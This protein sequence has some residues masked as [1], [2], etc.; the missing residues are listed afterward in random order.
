MQIFTNL[1][2]RFFLA[3][4]GFQEKDSMEINI[5]QRNSL[6]YDSH[7]IMTYY[8]SVNLELAIHGNLFLLASHVV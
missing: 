6:K 4:I 5:N 3:K 2:T 7:N 1:K 8:H